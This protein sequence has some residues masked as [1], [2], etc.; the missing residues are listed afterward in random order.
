MD[1]PTAARTTVDR[2]TVVVTGA[3]RGF[4]RAIAAVLVA[5]GHCVVGVARDA[6]DLAA[7]Q[8]EL[9]DRFVPVTGDVADP[10]M[11]ARLIEEHRPGMVVLAAGALPPMRPLHLLD[12]E[13]LSRPWQ[14]DVAQTFHWLQACL[15]RP[16]DPGSTVVTFSSGAAVQGSPLSGGYAGA[17]AMVRFLTSYAGEES[18]RAGLGLRFASVLPKLTPQTDLGAAAVAAYADR[19]GVDV[20]GFLDG[21]GPVTQPAVLADDV[22]RLLTDAS[23]DR[24]AYVVLPTGGLVPL[25]A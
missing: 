9:G 5:R 11:P 23:L 6:H 10:G 2:P 20:P 17:K 15:T 22:V 24:A 12:W 25:D 3:S 7:V 16:L 1:T 14:V 8:A 21:F 4:G 18:A 19:A 13:E